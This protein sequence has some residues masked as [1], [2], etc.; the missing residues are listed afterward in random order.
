MELLVPETNAILMHFFYNEMSHV[1][2][3]LPPFRPNRFLL[4]YDI[5]PLAA[6]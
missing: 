4:Q 1:A 3:W 5:V 2:E 6:I